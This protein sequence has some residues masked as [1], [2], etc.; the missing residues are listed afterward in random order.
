MS[1]GPSSTGVQSESLESESLK[2]E[3]DSGS[4]E[5]RSL[6][7]EFLGYLNQVMSELETEIR[8]REVG[9]SVPSVE[10]VRLPCA[11]GWSQRFSCRAGDL[12][13]VRFN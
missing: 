1:P 2:S 4:I 3:S 12:A 8:P 6:E 5:S 11:P 7:S 13:V 10:V 9:E